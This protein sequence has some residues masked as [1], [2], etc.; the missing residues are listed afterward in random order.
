VGRIFDPFVQ[1]LHS[2]NTPSDGVGLGLAISRDLARGMGG[3]IAVSS[4]VGSGSVFE[5][6]LP[7]TKEPHERMPLR[8]RDD[9]RLGEP[10]GV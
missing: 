5:F 8:R 6:V 4:T 7:A 1:V 2:Q 10:V 3:D 9:D